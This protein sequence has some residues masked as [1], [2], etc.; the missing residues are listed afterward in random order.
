MPVLI[1]E[2]PPSLY[3]S[4]KQINQM[5]HT[6]IKNYDMKRLNPKKQDIF[7]LKAGQDGF[8]KLEFARTRKVVG[9]NQLDEVKKGVKR[10]R[11]ASSMVHGDD[12]GREDEKAALEAG[13]QLGE[14]AL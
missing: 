3:C 5:H 11:E 2:R 4:I 1:A 8:L 9:S 6:C 13:K 7:K 12:A 14:H 10:S